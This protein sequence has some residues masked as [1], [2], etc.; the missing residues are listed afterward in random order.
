MS[1]TTPQQKRPR[2]LMT[3][4][5]FS[6]LVP[7]SEKTAARNR[8]ST[9]QAQPVPE[10]RTPRLFDAP[11]EDESK[12]IFSKTEED[13]SEHPAEKTKAVE[14][15]MQSRYEELPIELASLTDRFVDSLSAKVYATPPSADKLSD[16]FQEFYVRAA[17]T[18][19]I[20][21]SSLSSRIGRESSSTSSKSS[22]LS[23]TS[24]NGSKLRN[25]ISRESLNSQDGRGTEQQML[26]ADEVAERRKKRKLLEYR[27]VA[28]E[29][30][31]E[32]RACEKIYNK[33]W[34][35]NSTLDEIQDEKLRSRTAALS[36]VGIGLKDLGVEGQ[37]TQD[38]QEDSKKGDQEGSSE[39][40]QMMHVLAE[41]RNH[42][43]K[44]NNQRYPL[45]K[46]RC[47]AAAH[48]A[49][50]DA[51]STFHTASSSADE[52]LPT[53]IYT[54]ITMPPAE[55]NVVSHLRFIQRFRAVDK[56]DG[57]AAYCLTNL[58]AAIS[59]LETVDLASLREDE[60]QAP[61]RKPS[62]R[63]ATPLPNK[64]TSFSP[65]K[66]LSP[67]RPASASSSPPGMHPMEGMQR[68]DSAEIAKTPSASPNPRRLSQLLQP[69][70]KAFEAATESARNT[71]DQGLKNMGQAL[72]NSFK[73]LFGKMKEQEA[74]SSA[75]DG[76][77]PV[78]V[79][80][81]L[82]DARK[83][84]SPIL[85]P[86]SE[87]ESTMSGAS[88]ITEPTEVLDDP[89][90]KSPDKDSFLDLIGGRKAPREQSVDSNDSGRRVAFRNPA[91]QGTN[92]SSQRSLTSTPPNASAHA[93]PTALES[94]RNLGNT[95]NPLNR[96]ASTGFMRGFGRPVI[97]TPSPIAASAENSR[98]LGVVTEDGKVEGTIVSD[99]WKELSEKK[100][101]APIQRF[102][103][104]KGPGELK[105]SEVGE[106]LK[107]Y[108]RLAGALKERG[109]FIE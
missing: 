45:G 17:G 59:F 10:I 31:V 24:R 83:L 42:L 73:F 104:L 3:S 64:S 85:R 93:A 66:S 109:A 68:V 20:H 11:E 52:I 16:L 8:A 87:E 67:I 49:V 60:A 78:T 13:D 98:E 86:A 7:S 72:D 81:T 30:A 65:D 9:I 41:A 28:L 34:R 25:K 57:E 29:E 5:S 22:R 40:E 48:K 35:H 44:M 94:M 26:T 50:V 61:A 96:L 54:L 105:M 18:V 43:L 21:I 90:S 6:P 39:N 2:G 63:P 51:L 69:P 32:R 38:A 101:A 12:D 103:E 91:R 100:I 76:K 55:L 84:V 92:E 14:V 82:E 106:L 1:S 95:L 36:L 99:K 74:K 47:L 58:E 79:P 88:S 102:L 89:L 97:D 70:S 15:D 23:S 46:I 56:V 53:F 108:V 27:R 37:P 71:A 80:K 62:S 75:H 33:I 77:E 107:D 19:S 4:K